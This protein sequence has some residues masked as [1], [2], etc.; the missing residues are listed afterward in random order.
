[1]CAVA[2]QC[3]INEYVYALP[4][5]EA[6]KARE[7]QSALAAR[8]ETGGDIPGLWPIAVAAYFPLHAL[9]NA[10]A[11]AGRAWPPAVKALMIQQVEEPATE[12]RIAAALPALTP[13]EDEVSQA[14]R[15][16][17]EENPYPRWMRSK[18]PEKSPGLEQQ[19]SGPVPELLVAGCGTGLSLVDMSRAVVRAH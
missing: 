5:A 1:F 3:F 13:I 17:Y 14:V 12:R 7:L 4:D 10:A 18:P 19:A 16:Q 2:R 9:P 11:L 6:A 15:Q 8:I